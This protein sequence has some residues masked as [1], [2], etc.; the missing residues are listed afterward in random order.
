MKL[1]QLYFL[2][3]ISLFTYSGGFTQT[4]PFTI[5]I[6]EM[7]IPGLGGLQSFAFGQYDGKWLIIG[8]R[9]DGLHRRQPFAAFDQAGHNTLLFV[10]DPVT[11]QKWSSPITSLPISI[12]EQIKSTNMEFRQDGDF[13]YLIGGYGY[14]ATIGNHTTFSNMTAVNVPA[15]ISA[16]IS[17]SSLTANFRQI[18]DPQFQVTGGHL[19]KIYDTYYIIGGQKFIGQYNPMGPTSGPGFVQA[20]TDQIR[21]FKMT[22]D[23]TTITISHLAPWTDA[24][25][26]HRR[27]YNVMPQILP[28]GQEGA[29]AFSGVFQPTVNLPFLN[30]VVID[31][32][33][34]QVNPSFTQY[35]NHYHCAN[36]PLYSSDNNEMH[37]LFFGGIAQYYDN[38]GVLVQDN[39][40]PFVKTIARVTRDQ[41]G[42]M[43]EYKLPIEMPS[44]L[45][46]GSEFI[47]D[48][49]LPQF[50]N[51]VFKLDSLTADSTLLGYIYGGISSTGLNIF[52]TNDGTQSSASSQIFKVYLIKN[53]V[54]IDELNDHSTGS[55]KL[56]VFPNPSDGVFTVKYNLKRAS[57]VTISLFSVDGKLI[58]KETVLNQPAGEYLFEEKSRKLR[59]IGNYMLV[60]ET[61][62]ETAKQMISIKD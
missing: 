39:N 57:D 36:I 54:G 13:L 24:N 55:L 44:L 6:E 23:G 37:N 48:E 26:L 62:Y 3:L 61:N 7:S 35:Y 42:V 30:S 59:Y 10:V 52:T 8:G 2:T 12:Q 15:T 20:Y 28:N 47:P 38:N 34:Y 51:N 58:E 43:S 46:A 17:N 50:N 60:V 31:S 19:N 22:D 41:N 40:V 9:L 5:A 16:V 11:Q 1:F 14:S 25:N 29:T 49:S 21:R 45:G 27:D 32:N 4:T 56:I 33:N 53:V 18:T